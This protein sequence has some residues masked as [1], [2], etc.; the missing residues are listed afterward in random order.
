MS[1]NFFSVVTFLIIAATLNS[2][3]VIAVIEGGNASENVIGSISASACE[4]HQYEWKCC[5]NY[6]AK[7]VGILSVCISLKY[8]DKEYGGEMKV[9]VNN[10]AII[11]ER[12]SLVNPPPI[13]T[14]VPYLDKIAKACFYFYDLS[15]HND[16]VTGCLKMTGKIR[17]LRVFEFKIGCFNIPV[18][19]LRADDVKVILLH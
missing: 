19:K 5:A 18:K 9:T 10:F 16:H 15:F 14:D 2:V 3:A 17:F 1:I 13:C 8:L 11:D 12:L 6:T 4:T 7:E